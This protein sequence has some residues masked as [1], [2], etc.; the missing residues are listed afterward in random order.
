METI[1]TCTKIICVRRV[2]NARDHSQQRE[3]DLR[4]GWLFGSSYGVESEDS[5]GIENVRIEV[6]REMDKNKRWPRV[7]CAIIISKYKVLSLCLCVSRSTNKSLGAAAV[8]GSL[9]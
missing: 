4:M 3:V 5:A 7:H 2:E 8:R 6:A 1:Q 9:T